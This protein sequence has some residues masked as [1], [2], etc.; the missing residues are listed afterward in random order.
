MDKISWSKQ[1]IIVNKPC[2]ICSEFHKDP[3][4]PK[5]IKLSDCESEEGKEKEEENSGVL[6]GTIDITK[7]VFGVRNLV[8]MRYF[9]GF[10]FNL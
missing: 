10:V 4:A 6:V 2:P 7:P 3:L 8:I 5:I 9:L 1:N